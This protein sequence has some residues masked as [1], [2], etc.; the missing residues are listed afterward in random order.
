MPSVSLS[1][2]SQLAFSLAMRTH[3]DQRH[4]QPRLAYLK[5][6]VLYNFR[7]MAPIY[8]LE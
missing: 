8:L 5:P 2:W 6:M 3:G 1:G 7:Y 4:N